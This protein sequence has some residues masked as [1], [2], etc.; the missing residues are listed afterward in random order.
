VNHLDRIDWDTVAARD[1]RHPFV[2]EGKQAAFPVHEAFP[3]SLIRRIGTYDRTMA[4]RAM[5]ALH[6]ANHQPLVSVEAEWYY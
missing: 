1:F 3:W 4:E 5:Q 6:G 2:K